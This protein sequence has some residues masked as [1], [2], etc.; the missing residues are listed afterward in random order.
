TYSLPPSSRTN[1]YP[2]CT[3]SSSDTVGRINVS[4]EEIPL[5]RLEEKYK[6][7]EPGG[8]NIPRGCQATSRIAFIIP[9]RD[10]ESHLRILLNHMHSFLTRQMLD[11]SIIV[12]EQ[13]ANQTFNRA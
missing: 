10:R 9:F 4:L 1:N 2:R 13:V 6:Y 12:V 5:E 3:V 11:Y 8:H 7:L